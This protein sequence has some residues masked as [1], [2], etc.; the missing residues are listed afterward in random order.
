MNAF[1]WEKVDGTGTELADLEGID[2]YVNAGSLTW[3][4]GYLGTWIT[5]EKQTKGT[6]LQ[7]AKRRAQ[8]AAM[9]LYKLREQ[10]KP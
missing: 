2:L 8:A 10:R 1:V 5:D 4:A 7:D 9:I 6:D 3:G